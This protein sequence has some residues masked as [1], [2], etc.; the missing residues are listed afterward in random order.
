VKR[1]SPHHLERLRVK[2]GLTG[3]WQLYGNT[4]NDFE[5]I[6]KLDCRYIQYWS[7]WLDLKILLKTIPRILKGG[8]W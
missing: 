3:L 6:V 2:P 5:D 4:V 8:G 1:Y 7:V